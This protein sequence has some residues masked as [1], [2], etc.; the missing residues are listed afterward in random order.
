MS[1]VSL[2]YQFLKLKFSRY[3]LQTHSKD[4]KFCNS[5]DFPFPHPNTHQSTLRIRGRAKIRN[6]LGVKTPLRLINFYP[7]FKP[8]STR[9]RLYANT[10]RSLKIDHDFTLIRILRGIVSHTTLSSIF[11]ALLRENL[12][13]REIIWYLPEIGTRKQTASAFLIRYRAKATTWRHQNISLVSQLQ[14]TDVILHLERKPY[15]TL[16]KVRNKIPPYNG[17]LSVYIFINWMP[18][19]EFQCK[20]YFC[21]YIDTAL[22]YSIER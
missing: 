16:Q 11:Q 21:N 15:N 6:L 13:V 14:V 20:M 8:D 2:E 3:Q 22:Y 9:Y 4:L 10:R 12:N 7:D 5:I 18:E 19:R 17:Y 1:A